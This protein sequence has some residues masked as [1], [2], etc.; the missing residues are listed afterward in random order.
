MLWMPIKKAF[1]IGMDNFSTSVKLSVPANTQGLFSASL[2]QKEREDMVKRR[3]YQQGSLYTRGKR[4]EVWVAR[5]REDEYDANGNAHRVL[6]NEVL[7]A[8]DAMTRKMALRELA[9]RLERINNPSYVPE[10]NA[11]FIEFAQ[12]WEKT[13]LS[14][15]K[16]STQAS[17]GSQLRTR[18][19]PYFGGIVMRDI[20]QPDIQQ[21]I[22]SLTDLQ[23]DTC[24][25]LIRTMKMMWDSADAGSYVTEWPFRKLRLPKNGLRDP[26]FYHWEDAKR[27][28]NMA[29]EPYK[30][31]LW[32]AYETGIRAGELSGL[33]V[34]NVILD[35]FLIRVTQSVWRGKVQTVKSDH[36]RRAFPISLELAAHLELYIKHWKP[37]DLNLLFLAPRGGPIN[38]S[39]VQSQRL[40]PICKKLGIPCRGLRA[41]RHGNTSAMEHEGISEKIQQERLGHRPGSRVTKM[42]YTHTVSEDHRKAADLIGK[43]L[44]G[45]SANV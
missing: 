4:R 42:H 27:I 23:P 5:W 13:V 15:H 32:V 17:I 24:R 22:S 12:H 31:L 36:S 14:Q 21:F 43:L 11:T 10:R 34:D 30:T 1:D 40:K 37:N 8:K 9:S 44:A 19:I 7:G 29:G 35:E 41:F 33:R 2:S 28:W 3:R 25:N 39:D 18:L 26:Y 45:C 20:R 6:R 38:P 16:P